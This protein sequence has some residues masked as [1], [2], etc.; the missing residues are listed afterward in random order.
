M[1][2]L[3]K[4]IKI[5]ECVEV[6]GNDFEF[7]TKA[8]FPGEEG[9]DIV[10]DASNFKR[11]ATGSLHLFANGY[12]SR[13]CPSCPR[14]TA[15]AKKYTLPEVTLSDEIV[16]GSEETGGEGYTPIWK[17]DVLSTIGPTGSI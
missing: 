1:A 8:Y 16:G 11:K 7:I 4:E 9:K 14:K 10:V 15:A 12:K 6:Y 5:N 17:G 2:P 13:T 3:D